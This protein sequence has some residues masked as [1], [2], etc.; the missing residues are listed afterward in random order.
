[1][2]N[3]M[4]VTPSPIKGYLS[5]ALLAAL[6]LWGG[7]QLGLYHCDDIQRQQQGL[8][9]SIENLNKANHSLTRQLHILGVELEV[10]KQ[11]NLAAQKNIKDY[12]DKQDA[13]REELSFYQKVTAPELTEQGFSIESFNLEPGAIEGDY[14]YALVLMQRNQ[15]KSALKGQASITLEGSEGGKPK[16]YSLKGLDEDQQGALKF[17]FKYFALLEGRLRLP[18]NF[19]PNRVVVTTRVRLPG[20]KTGELTR[21]FAWNEL[22]PSAPAS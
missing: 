7:Y 20:N 8:M 10:E 12:I 5:A 21:T 15:R 14:R 22:L 9:S 4:P 3:Q 13:L 2:T 18:L 6:A 16:Q 19:I 11:A 17:S 1:M